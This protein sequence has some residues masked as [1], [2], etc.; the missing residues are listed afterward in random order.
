MNSRQETP[1][2]QP[3]PLPRLRKGQ[4]ARRGAWAGPAA[5]ASAWLLALAV[6]AAVLMAA[7]APVHAQST[8]PAMAGAAAAPRD[9]QLAPP[10]APAEGRRQP[11]RQPAVPAA[12]QAGLQADGVAGSGTA[13]ALAE[14]VPQR[15]KALPTGAQNEASTGKP[16]GQANKQARPI[17]PAPRPAR[18]PRRA[19]E[20]QL[21]PTPRILG[22]AAAASNGRGVLTYGPVLA[23]PPP[24]P[25]TPPA[26]GSAPANCAGANCLDAGGQRLG[27]GIGNTAITPQG[28]LCT[29]GLAG[30]QCF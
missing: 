19:V 25:V 22:S 3:S 12:A 14:G 16:D 9:A 10:P 27:T 30:L 13:G 8:P 17:A 4:A 24:L 20:Q 29:R 23:S 5:T 26:R 7:A 11:L 6:T 1:A 15:S 21:T 18:P 2:P 28:Q